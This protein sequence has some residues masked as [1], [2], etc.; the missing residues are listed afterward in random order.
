VSDKD[1]EVWGRKKMS[2]HIGHSD[3]F[4]KKRGEICFGGSIVRYE[5]RRYL[6]CPC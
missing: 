4:I 2:D 1:G 5:G 6:H 3:V